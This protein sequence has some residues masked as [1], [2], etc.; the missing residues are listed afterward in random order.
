MKEVIT[1]DQAPRTSTPLSQAIKANGFV[2]VSGQIGIDPA[3]SAL[4][5]GGIAP[6]T[7]QTIKNIRAILH[8]AGSDLSKVVKVM[9][10]LIDMNDRDEMNRVY[11]EFFQIDPPARAAVEVSRLAWGARIEMDVIALA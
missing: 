2:F 4:V 6:E 11:R 5:Q 10:H 9:I 8:A 1:T 7:E 3:T